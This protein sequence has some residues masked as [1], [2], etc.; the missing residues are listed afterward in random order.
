MCSA[1][2]KGHVVLPICW[3]QPD[4]VTNAIAEDCEEDNTGKVSICLLYVSV[5]TT[6]TTGSQVHGRSHN[7]S[8]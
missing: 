6:I 5:L 2:G 1:K 4:P 3:L 8:G 7:N